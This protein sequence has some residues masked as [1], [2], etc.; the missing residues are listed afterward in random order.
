MIEL[1]NLKKSFGDLH[2]LCDVSTRIPKGRVTAVVGPNGSGKTTL[3]KCIL[4]LVRP[5]AGTITI[6]GTTLNGS[7]RYRER[8][9]YMPQGARFPENL[10]AREIIAMLKDLRGNPDNVDEELI[11]RFGLEPEMDKPIRTLSGGNR[12]KVN[13]VT[14]F[15]FRPDVVILDE[16][17]AGLDPAAS[18]ILKDK[19]QAEQRAGTTFILTSHV[20]SELEELSGHLA[21][22]LDGAIRFDGPIDELKASTGSRNL[23]RAIAHLMQGNQI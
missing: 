16:P 19:I 7:W 6:D 20:M 11:D 9:G 4:G 5:D 2:V 23:E 12:Q 3:I 14:A 13:A 18:S 22:L 17:T 1:Q 8:I 15:L 21:F 10:T